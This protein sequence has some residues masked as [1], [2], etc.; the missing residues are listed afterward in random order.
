MKHTGYRV[1]LDK[2]IDINEANCESNEANHESTKD[3]QNE[4]IEK[5]ILIQKL[6]LTEKLTEKLAEKLAERISHEFFRKCG[7]I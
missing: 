5:T 4:S 6:P 7:K 2:T 3:F 1:A